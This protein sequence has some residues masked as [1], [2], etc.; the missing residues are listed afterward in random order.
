MS[1]YFDDYMKASQYGNLLTGVCMGFIKWGDI[2]QTDKRALAKNLLW[3][4]RQSKTEVPVSVLEAV[5]RVLTEQ[6]IENELK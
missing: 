6:E 5:G 4:H 2:S 3:C 1:N